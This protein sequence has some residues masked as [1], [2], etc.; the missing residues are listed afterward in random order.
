MK[1][2]LTTEDGSFF[3]LDVS[4]DLELE[5]F[6]ALLEFESEIPAAQVI[7]SFEGRELKDLKKT[8]VDYGVKEGDML[9][10]RRQRARAAPRSQGTRVLI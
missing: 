6:H 1:I 8:L 4:G 3:S 9:L 10:I 2:T 7:V 5:N